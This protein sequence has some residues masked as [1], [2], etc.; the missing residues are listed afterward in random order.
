MLT[1]AASKLRCGEGEQI[2]ETRLAECVK[3]AEQLRYSL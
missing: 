2:H 1:K 3:L